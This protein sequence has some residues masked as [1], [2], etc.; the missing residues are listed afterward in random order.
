VGEPKMVNV[1]SHLI[2]PVHGISSLSVFPRAEISINWKGFFRLKT[3]VK[4]ASP[5]ACLLKEI[6]GYES[7]K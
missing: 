4:K 2:Y 5:V 1:K 6:R 7:W 3:G